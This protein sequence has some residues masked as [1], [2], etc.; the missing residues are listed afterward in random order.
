MVSTGTLT[1]DWSI[2][3]AAKACTRFRLF[4]TWRL[5]DLPAHRLFVQSGT[6]D[7]SDTITT[8]TQVKSD[9]INAY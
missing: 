7:P 1:K 9:A 5:L 6:L 3:V 4:W 8:T 2:V